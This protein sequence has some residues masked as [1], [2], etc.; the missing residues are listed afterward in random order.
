MTIQQ[1]EPKPPRNL[2]PLAR[3]ILEELASRPG[4][5]RIIVG[6]GVALQHYVEHRTTVDLD[7]WWHG[8]IE[9]AVSDAI[10]SAMRT[11]GERHG[12]ELRER[13][14]RETQSYELV[15]NE[16]K[17]FSFQIAL[18]TVELDPPLESAWPP[19]KIE[20]LRDNLGAKMNALVDRGAPRDF[21][22]TYAISE[23]GLARPEDCWSTWV[24]KNPGLDVAAARLRV[25]HHLETLEGRRPLESVPPNEREKARLL[26]EWVR[27][28]LCGGVES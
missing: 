7:A 8:S 17:A 28:T 27:K 10:R 24:A 20:S 4:T 14:W 3:E 9:P 13:N 18:R 5:D 21:I 25:I 19:V 22:D 26:R 16:K 11:V 1:I 6:G 12:L 23:A 2:H 15:A